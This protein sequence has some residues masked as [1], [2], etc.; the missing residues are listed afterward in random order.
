MTI[1]VN[2]SSLDNWQGE[3]AE[4]AK[5]EQPGKLDSDRENWT[6]VIATIGTTFFVY[7][8]FLLQGVMVARL[9]GPLGRGEFGTA[10]YVPRD[11]LLYT[12]LLGGIEIVN[13]YAS[14]RL[15]GSIDLKYSAM[16]LGWVSGVITAV[17]AAVLSTVM[18][19]SV[20]KAYLLPYCW[21]CCLFV[22]WEHVHLVVSAVDRGDRNFGAYNV[23][24][25][26]FALAFPVMVAA[27][28]SLRLYDYIP[29]PHPKLL[30]VTVVFVTSRILGLLPT[31]RGMKLGTAFRNWLTS[32][33][34]KSTSQSTENR[35]QQP[36]VG[37]LLV[38]GRPYAFSMFATELFERLDVLLI[39][40]F[41]AVETSGHYFVA[42]P[43]ASLLT[44]I[45][46]ALGVFTFN[47]GASPDKK[48]SARQAILFLSGTAFVQVLST[49]VF[50]LIVPFL[51]IF[52]FTEA[53]R[54]SIPFVIALAPACAIKGYLQTVDGFLKGRGKP[55]LGV[56]SRLISIVGMIVFFVLTYPKFDLISIPLSACFGQGISM[57]LLSIAAVREVHTDTS[58][59]AA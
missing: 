1:S 11:I 50:C 58:E 9:L 18:L 8:I 20:G 6:H 36:Q 15:T 39:V 52:M 17:I 46:N 23:N 12:G 5:L 37:Q 30:L 51:I 13:S 43:A 21:I 48:F 22:P 42:V 57:I 29:G 7:G 27:T 55:M 54:E 59:K 3:T 40:L 19:L 47:A 49:I 31:L 26:L 34:K 32:R 14:R 28:F 45:P 35:A 53:Y 2:S 4:P 10:L 41:A 38:E 44:V 16:R 25:I 24:R 33:S 56:H